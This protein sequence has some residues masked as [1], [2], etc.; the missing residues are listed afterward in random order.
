MQCSLVLVEY[1]FLMTLTEI[2]EGNTVAQSSKGYVCTNYKI[3]IFKLTDIVEV[4]INAALSAHQ[5]PCLV[6]ATHPLQRTTL[7]S[8]KENSG[9][10]FKLTEY[11]EFS[12]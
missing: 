2:L 1:A 4:V 7:S 10:L 11:H 5:T 12:C 8:E 9:L 3:P 6:S